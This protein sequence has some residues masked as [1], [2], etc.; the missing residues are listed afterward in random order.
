MF[1]ITI[2]SGAMPKN[3]LHILIRPC[4]HA[5]IT[6]IIWITYLC[7]MQLDAP[8]QLEAERERRR[9]T[10]IKGMMQ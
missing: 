3:I 7:E 8:I 5:Q 1:N 10:G 4:R 9:P 6:P 2:T